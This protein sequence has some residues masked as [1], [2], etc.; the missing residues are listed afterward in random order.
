[1]LKSLL[2]LADYD[3]AKVALETMEHGTD[4]ILLCPHEISQIKKVAGLIE[5]I[6]SESYQIETSHG[7]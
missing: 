2:L 5:K 3:E 6:Q 7:N 4:G 1:M